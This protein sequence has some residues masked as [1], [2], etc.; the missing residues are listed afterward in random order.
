M[1]TV[2]IPA[3]ELL[4]QLPQKSGYA[5]LQWLE[6]MPKVFVF[7]TLQKRTPE[8]EVE[9]K[10]RDF[11]RSLTYRQKQI[12]V[13]L[14]NRGKVSYQTLFADL[15]IGGEENKDLVPNSNILNVHTAQVRRKMK[16]F[17][18]PLEILTHKAPNHSQT[19]GA[20]EMVEK[21][22]KKD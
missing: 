12:F 9:E 19:G 22:G 21:N 18:L 3:K 2:E 17:N 11:Y 14:Y 15:N 5:L 16:Q 4:R 20:Y 7:Q 8:N 1:I 10:Y 6:E 13:A